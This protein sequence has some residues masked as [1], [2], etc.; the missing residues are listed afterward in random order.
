MEDLPNHIKI[1]ILQYI[2]R[3]VQPVAIIF[4]TAFNMYDNDMEWW[5][6][7]DYCEFCGEQCNE[8]SFCWQCDYPEKK[9][10]KMYPSRT[11]R[12]SRYQ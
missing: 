8:E 10:P 1:K 9:Y 6:D 12:S 5:F 7:L 3:R 2:P 11:M 4:K